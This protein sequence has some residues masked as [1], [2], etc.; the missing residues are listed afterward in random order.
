MKSYFYQNALIL[1][2]ALTGFACTDRDRAGSAEPVVGRVNGEPILA[3]ELQLMVRKRRGGLGEAADLSIP[4]D[5]ELNRILQSMVD[6]RLLEQ[7]ARQKQIVVGNSEIDREITR[8]KRGWANDDFDSIMAGIYGDELVFRAH[9]RNRLVVDKYLRRHIFS[10]IAVRD[11][12]IET[13]L[14]Q[15]LSRYLSP[16][17]IR[18]RQILLDTQEKASRIHMELRRSKKTFEDW[19]I[20]VSLGPEAKNGGDL[21]FF[22]LGEM[23]DVFERCFSMWK[24][25]VSGVVKSDF[26]FHIFKLIEKRPAQTEPTQG[27]RKRIEIEL[28]TEKERTALGEHLLKLRAKAEMELPEEGSLYVWFKDS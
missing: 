9:Q 23:P 8:L 13:H 28:R 2:L 1:S 19:A 16:A 7:A 24:G 10:R 20:E 27:V 3:S 14:E 15:N 5:A 18:V 4:P 25:Q 26:G 6:E 22:A 17:R 21:G 12:E 11:G